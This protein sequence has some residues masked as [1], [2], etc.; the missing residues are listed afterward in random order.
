MKESSEGSDNRIKWEGVV[1][2]SVLG[3]FV[4]VFRDGETVPPHLTDIPPD[5][6]AT[7]IPT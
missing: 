5:K 1:V 3:M 6:R 2:L 4:S 7:D